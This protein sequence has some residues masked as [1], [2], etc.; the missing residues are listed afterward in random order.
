MEKKVIKILVASPS[1]TKSERECCL[2]VFEELN[3]GIGEKFGFVIE[4]RMWEH[5]TRPSIGE[6]SQS[7][8][9]EQLGN[10]YHVFVGIMNN[11]FGTETKKAGS[12]TEEE[13]NNA[14]NRIIRKEPIEI[15]F[16]FNDE[17][18]SKKSEIN[19]TELDK[20]EAF[21]KK[22][23]ELGTY[24]WTYSGVQDFEKTFRRQLTDHLLKSE[25]Q[26]KNETTKSNVQ[27]EVLR[28]KFKERLD[29]AL[30]AFSTQPII[31]LEPVLSNTNEIS[32]NPDENYTKRVNISELIY[33]PDSFVINAP[34]QFGMTCLAHYLVCEAWEKGDLWLYL[35]SDETKSHNIHKA[36]V[37]EA[38][39]LG[40]KIT[41]VKA[42]ILDSWNN[43][44]VDSLRKLKNLSDSYKDIPLI[45]MHRIDDAKFLKEKHDIK[46]E[47]KFHPLFLLALPRTQIRKA[48]A[49]YNR[50]REIGAEDKVLTKVVSDLEMLNIHRT[51]M[52]CFT[53]LKVAEKYFDESPINRTD[54]IEKVLFVLFNMDGLPRYRTK[55][56]LKD[57]EYVLGRFCEKM[58]KSHKFSFTRDEFIKDL[59]SY[60]N[61]KLIDLEIE[62]VFDILAANNIIVKHEI[63]F[64]F[65]AAFWVYYFAARRM[66]SDPAFAEYIFTSKN[67]TACPEIIEFYTGID[68]NKLDALEILTKDIKQTCDIVNSKVRLT[69]DMDVFSH[70]RW[71][72][73]EE[74]IESAQNQLSE[75]V[76]NSGLPDNIKDQHADRSYNQMRPYNQSIQAFFEEYSL[77]NLMQNISASARALRNSDY[78]KPEAKREILSEI[79]RSWE[80]I[81]NVL[82]ALTPILAAKGEA[83]FDGQSFTLHG[84]FGD[85]FEIRVKRIIQVNMTNVVGFFKDDIYSSKIAPLL[86]EQFEKETDARKK[87]KI[88]LLLIFCRPRE[89][90]KQIQNYIVSLQKNSFYLY[91]THNALLSKYNFDF[92]T[93]EERREIS[94][95]VKMCFA[96][97]EFGSKNPSPA[98]LAKVRISK[99]KNVDGHE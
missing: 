31:W 17:L 42:I 34:P 28:A 87:H 11:K 89:W 60:C 64:G 56:D 77:H 66:H 55:P 36:A 59:K 73:T 91:D 30:K 97:H 85:T 18:P 58:I 22:V 50:V 32:Q 96:K 86:Y 99:P 83:G 24:Y 9:N 94:L 15:M 54:M 33:N 92:I 26:S 45:V 74:Q 63:D 70:I 98:E 68:R 37:R 51:A 67:Y 8:V 44:E 39:S 4:E 62:I 61:E 69:G 6:Y 13:F 29:K 12:G 79:L 10:D 52:N 1:D 35:D 23:A 40:M 72:P 49:E 93:E 48:V 19:T 38:D 43:Y 21:K 14:Y 84:D 57:C 71:Q 16:Y 3:K 41:D 82:L 25:G 88:A 46:I 2:R 90:R 95:L 81:S 47:R 65:R 80:Q 53:L 27:F 20:I 75:S 7:V 76:L 78:V 5:N